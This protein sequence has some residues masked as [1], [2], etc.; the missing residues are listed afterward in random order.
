MVLRKLFGLPTPE[1]K[2][3]DQIYSAIV[4]QARQ[5]VFYRD[6]GVPDTLDGRFDMISLHLVLVLHRMKSKRFQ[7]LGQTL[8]DTFFGN[9][10]DSLREMGVGDLTV[11]KKVKAMSEA[12]YGRISAYD[13]G[14]D[15]T[16]EPDGP[17]RAR[18][19]AE[20]LQRNVFRSEDEA[21][22]PGAQALASYM[23]WEVRALQAQDDDALAGGQIRFSPAEETLGTLLA[24]G[25]AEAGEAGASAP[26]AGVS[27]KTVRP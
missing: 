11:P 21:P 26:T 12:L 15:L 25:A 1:R 9:M 7:E 24:Q 17:D 22:L 5:P 13:P 10:D 6:A 4:A 2:A 19:L 27:T 16:I 8:F 20:A 18:L 3:A 14:L 23:R